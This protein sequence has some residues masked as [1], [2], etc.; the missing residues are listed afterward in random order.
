MTNVLLQFSDR[1]TLKEAMTE[2]SRLRQQLTQAA[3]PGTN[4]ELIA[5]LSQLSEVDT[6]ALAVMLQLDRQARQ[7]FSCPIRWRGAPASLISLARLSSLITVLQWED[8]ITP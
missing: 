5:D 4:V 8:G 6:S 7:L 1:L 3:K 2:L